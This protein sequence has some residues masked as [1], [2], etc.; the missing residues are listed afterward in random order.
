MPLARSAVGG[1]FAQRQKKSPL[2]LVCHVLVSV[3]LRRIQSSY[4]AVVLIIS[5]HVSR[6]HQCIAAL[7]HLVSQHLCHQMLP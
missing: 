1:R 4:L 6:W 3:N 7:L 2:T 5:R